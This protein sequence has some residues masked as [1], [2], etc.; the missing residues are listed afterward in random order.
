[1]KRLYGFR[2]V[3]ILLMFYVAI[4]SVV[5]VITQCGCASLDL[6]KVST[7]QPVTYTMR[8]DAM[9]KDLAFYRSVAV[10]GA[11]LSGDQAKLAFVKAKFDE[12]QLVIDG[13]RTY[14]ALLDSK[15]QLDQEK[16]TQILNDIAVAVGKAKS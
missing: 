6:Q 15:G 8:I 12:A 9:E 1:M 11:T 2:D 16:L 7:T 4:L 5:T 14:A 3:L 13:G 10:L